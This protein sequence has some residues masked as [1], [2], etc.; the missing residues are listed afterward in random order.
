MP[1][2]RW[3][4]IKS[5]SNSDAYN[6]SGDLA[7]DFDTAN[8]IVPVSSDTQRNALTPPQGS[9]AGMVVART[10]IA[11]SP[12]ERFDG[13]KWWGDAPHEEWTFSNPANTVPNGTAWGPGLG[14]LDTANSIYSGFGS[15]STND[16]LAFNAPGRYLVHWYLVLTGTT[17][18]PVYMSIRDSTGAVT[19]TSHQW[20]SA[21]ECDISIELN[22]AAGAQVKF[23]FV[24]TGGSTYNADISHRIRLSKNG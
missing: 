18:A 5:I 11:Q 24:Q 19:Y 10:D 12:I 22:L 23:V 17:G 7:T 3:N 21:F 16:I 6:L 15:S 9:Y 1:Q 13:T 14:T 20:P 8:V 4:G 2:T